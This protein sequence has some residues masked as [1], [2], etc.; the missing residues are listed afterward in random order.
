MRSSRDSRLQRS[1]E[2]RSVHQRV[3]QRAHEGQCRRGDLHH[4]L[5]P[6]PLASAPAAHHRLLQLAVLWSG[7]RVPGLQL[8]RPGHAVSTGC[9]RITASSCRSRSP[10]WA[11][12]RRSTARCPAL[13]AERPAQDAGLDPRHRRRR[14]RGS[15]LLDLLA[16]GGA[17]IVAWHRPGG[18]P[19]FPAPRTTWQAVDLLD[20]GSGPAGASPRSG[21]PPCTTAPGLR[22]SDGPG[23]PPNR[24]SPPTS[25]PPTIC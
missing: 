13:P 10:A 1:G 17:D 22:T 24:H 18:S 2:P 8:Q 20:R 15:H 25:A 12:S 7:V 23:T 4:Q 5:R 19:A 21:Q 9:P 11:T 3:G 6:A 16:G 14:I